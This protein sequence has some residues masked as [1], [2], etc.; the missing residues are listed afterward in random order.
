MRLDVI[1]A[2]LFAVAM[3]GSA[4]AQEVAAPLSV[5]STS[6]INVDQVDGAKA[7]A[8]RAKALPP[9]DASNVASLIVAGAPGYE[10][11]PRD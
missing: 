8:A 4:L 11:S 7:A 2:M 1:L 3:L 6:T 9:P 10:P 5:N